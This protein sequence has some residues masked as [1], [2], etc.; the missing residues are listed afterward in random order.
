MLES[1]WILVHA[2]E[3][4]IPKARNTVYPIKI[5]ANNSDVAKKVLP[6][7][8]VGMQ[9]ASLVSKGATF[10][11][12]LAFPVP[13]VEG[14]ALEDTMNMATGRCESSVAEFDVLQ[15]HTN[16]VS[17]FEGSEPEKNVRGAALRELKAFLKEHDKND[18]FCGLRKIQ[19]PGGAGDDG[20]LVCW[21]ILTD[22]EIGG[23]VHAAE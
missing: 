3:P 19:R 13:V 7:M 16:D 1:Q 11:R 15:R 14:G 21:T 5:T 22:E 6:L 2:G 12:M 18:N 20:P 23:L 9:A 10:G 8:K 17:M 4:V